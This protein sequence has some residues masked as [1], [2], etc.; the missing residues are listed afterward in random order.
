MVDRKFT[1]ILRAEPEGGFTVLVPALPE[2][3]TYGRDEAEAVEH[4]KEAIE[5]AIEHRVELG[6][7]VPDDAVLPVRSVSVQI[8]TAPDGSAAGTQSA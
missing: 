5:L 3:V 7:E 4:A 6:E 8:P 1:V 2:V